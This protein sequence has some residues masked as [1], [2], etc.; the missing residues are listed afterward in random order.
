MIADQSYTAVVN[1]SGNAAITIK[2]TNSRRY[3]SVQQVSVAQ[4]TA[5]IGAACTLTKNGVFVTNLV[6]QGD[7]A[8]GDPP[9]L[10]HGQDVMVVTFTGCTPGAVAQVFVIYDETDG[11]GRSA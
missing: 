1:G 10:L 3:W 2:P 11:F 7:S 4:A 8:A 9:V 5:P 6:A